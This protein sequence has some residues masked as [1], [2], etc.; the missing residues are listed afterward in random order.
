MVEQFIRNEM[1]VGSI[2]TLGKSVAH[3]GA[4]CS[5]INFAQF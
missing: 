4:Q 3:G 1:V 5:R 2:P